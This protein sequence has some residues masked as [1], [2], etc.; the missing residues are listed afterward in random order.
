MNKQT[1]VS[2]E[3]NPELTIG[4]DL[5][6][7]YSH[8]CVLD[9]SGEV[10]EDGRVATTPAGLSRRFGSYPSSRVALEVGT[11]SPWT[12]RLLA[13]MGHEVLVANARK[14]RAIY[15][16]EMKSDSVDAQMLARIA[17]LDPQLLSP[18]RHRGRA[19]QVDLAVVRSRS[20]LVRS[21][22]RLVN[23]VRG[24]LKAYG[25]RLRKCSTR[26]FHRQAPES[27]PEELQPALEPVVQMIGELTER[28]LAY[29]RA[30]EAMAEQRY[31]QTAVL[32]QVPGV[33]PLTAVTYVLTLEDPR[34]FSTSRTVGAYLGL[35]PRRDQS[36]ERDPQLRITK[37][38]NVNLRWMLVQCAHYI[39]GPLAPD[40][41]LRRWGLALARRG[42]K[43]AKRRAT[44]AVA[45]KLAV[46][47]HRLWVT[48]EVYEPLRVASPRD[49]QRAVA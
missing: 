5:G 45:R 30:L 19:F 11:H 3:L 34:R 16:N 9:A 48:G 10:V 23:H 27:I 41:A 25:V 7:R 42:G 6:D 49:V 14:L 21:R 33:G 26:S 36:G 17:R 18:I 31:P 32:R 43:Q 37:C 1:S 15:T 28:I 40:T 35:T 29:D 13:K 46:L 8:F 24:T 39:L 38:G 20:A 22:T 4:V 44:V 2:T 47:L 12:S